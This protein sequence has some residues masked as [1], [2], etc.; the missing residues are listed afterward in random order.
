MESINVDKEKLFHLLPI[1]QYLFDKKN[2][3]QNTIESNK[4]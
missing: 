1:I 2:Y 4:F 3:V